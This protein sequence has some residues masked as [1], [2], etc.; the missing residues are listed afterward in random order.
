MGG[1]TC[2]ICADKKQEK[3]GQSPD[4]APAHLHGKAPGGKGMRIMTQARLLFRFRKVLGSPVFWAAV[5]QAMGAVAV[6]LIGR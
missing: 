6:A 2:R 1:R 4:F 5:L 3:P